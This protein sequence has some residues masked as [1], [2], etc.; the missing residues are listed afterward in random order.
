[1]KRPFVPLRVKLDAA[2]LQLGLDPKTAVLD[3]HPPLAQRVLLTCGHYLPSANDPRYLQW[4]APEAHA[5]KTTGRRGTSR[6]SK[7]GG[8]VSEIA[9]TRRLEDMRRRFITAVE[10]AESERP[11]KSKQRR[12]WPKRKIPSR[13]MRRS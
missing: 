2:L 7:R 13:K 8:D 1:M 3:H 6:L 5:E 9:K 12:A 4:L 11:S 10:I